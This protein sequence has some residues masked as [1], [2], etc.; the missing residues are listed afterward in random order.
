MARP[1]TFDISVVK[2]VHGHFKG[3]AASPRLAH[4]K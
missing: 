2:R 3:L 1:G 4:E